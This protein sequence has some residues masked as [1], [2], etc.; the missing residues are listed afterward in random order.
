MIGR[1]LCCAAAVWAG[2]VWAAPDAAK[3]APE[4][5]WPD[6]L[7]IDDFESGMGKWENK[8]TGR[9]ELVDDAPQGKKA[10]RWTAG[11]DG[12]GHIVFKGLSRET[13]DFSKYE[14]LIFRV[15]V[16]GKPLWNINPIIQ[17]YPAV[18]GYRG[19]YSSI[20]TMMPYDR[21]YVFTQDLRRWENAW[22][23]TFS[24]TLEEFQFEIQQLAG[25]GRTVVTL[26]DIRLMKN[27]LGLDKSYPGRHIAAADGSQTTHFRLRMANRGATPLTVRF[28]VR[29]GSLS[30]FSAELPAE[31]CRLLPGESGEALVRVV[32]PAALAASLPAWY[33]ETAVVGASVEEIPGLVLFTEL[34]A[35]TRPKSAAHPCILADPGRVA[36]WRKEWNDP[37]RR[38]AM[39]PLFRLFV[40]LGERDLG[41]TPEFPAIGHPGV[42][43]C[44]VDGAP[45]KPLD[46]PNLPFASYQCPVCGRSY[47]GPLYDAG[48]GRWSAKHLENARAVRN[49]GFAYAVTGRP[50]FAK[51]AAAIL[52][53]Y[54]PVYRTIPVI[55]FSAGS[56]VF[57]HTS[58]ASRIGGSYMAERNW[59]AAL[60]IGLDFIRPAGVLTDAEVAA[61]AADVFSPSAHLMMDHKVGAMNLQ[62]MI[63][64][65]ALLGGLATDDT[66]VVARA[67]YDTHGVVNLM[68]VGYL[69]DG[70]WWENPSYQNVA[71]GVAFPVLATCIQNGILPWDGKL[72]SIFTAAYRL[73]GP[74]GRSPTL[75]TGGPGG[76]GYSDNALHSL[77]SFLDDPRLAWVAWNRPVMRASSSGDTPYDSYIWAVTWGGGTPKVAKEQAV[78]PIPDAT[79]LAPDYGGIALRVPGKGNYA[80]LHFGREL[81]HGHRNKLSVNAYA[82]GNWFVRNVAGGYGDNFKNFLETIASSTTI[83]V[84]GANPDGDTGELLFL[85]S[86][87]GIEIAAGR[88]VGAWKDVEHE[89]A[90]VLTGGPLIVLD[91]CRADGEHTYDWLYQSALTGLSLES[92]GLKPAGVERFGESPLY[93][94][95][96]PSFAFPAPGPA[97]LARKDGSGLRV[98]LLPRGTLSA[99]QALKKT[100]GLLWRQRGRTVGFAAVLWPYAKGEEG[101]VAIAEL[102][103]TDAAGKPVGLSEGQ[104]VEVRTPDGR[105]Q[106]LV[107]YTGRALRAGTLSGTDRVVAAAVP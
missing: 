86:A 58:G 72:T 107:N 13:V 70:N 11:D 79:T 85:R 42:T 71:N 105:Y 56:P 47:S 89:R 55:A 68:R 94:S 2:A 57:S 8:D 49:L 18:Y 80:Y 87:D 106:V 97:R 28:H 4:K 7:V 41:H 6:V 101:E 37:E 60:A 61:I 62:W 104:A 43:T 32:V 63:A 21:W 84:D 100:D 35:G 23:D 81:V 50:E 1:V 75:G 39:D 92:A 10:L 88:E 45:L 31:P 17:Q 48:M 64:G 74:D 3:K 69:P 5:V 29:E 19:L 9:L 67:M 95:L 96:V 77:A 27:P 93:E 103:V 90:V 46:V 91:R 36:R 54:V 40:S 52:R 82:K 38:K 20:D 66:N 78:S 34:T 83:M 24:A 59:L 25:A 99:F 102:K 53:A 12:I 16:S 33:G 51:A 14:T 15:K 98:A 76:Y 26:D 30:K 44:T 22:P 65:G 73:Y